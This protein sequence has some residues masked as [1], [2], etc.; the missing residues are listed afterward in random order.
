MRRRDEDGRGGEAAAII[1]WAVVVVGILYALAMAIVYVLR[2][3]GRP[4]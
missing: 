3:V 4:W 2:A 1:A